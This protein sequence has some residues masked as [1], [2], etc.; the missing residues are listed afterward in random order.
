MPTEKDATALLVQIAQTAIDR[1]NT[2][3]LTTWDEW[4]WRHIIT[5]ACSHPGVRQ[6]LEW[7]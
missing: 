5:V 1:I 3:E 6:G 7:E 2:G 4:Y